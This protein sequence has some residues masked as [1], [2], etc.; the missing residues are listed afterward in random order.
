MVRHA[1][2]GLGADGAYGVIPLSRTDRQTAANVGRD[3]ADGHRVSLKLLVFNGPLLFGR[4]NLAEI[5]QAGFALGLDPGAH[6]IGDSHCSEETDDDH[7]DHDFDH[8]KSSLALKLNS[9]GKMLHR[10]PET[11]F[12]AELV[13]SQCPILWGWRAYG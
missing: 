9:H 2:G 13:R 7:D 3:I 8:R 11:Q 12:G 5:V 1:A 10:L 6:Q 4:I